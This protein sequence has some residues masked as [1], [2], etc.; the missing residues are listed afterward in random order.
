V[1]KVQDVVTTEFEIVD[2]P[3]RLAI[4]IKDHA[5]VADIPTVMARNLR[6][7]LNYVQRRGIEVSGPPFT[8]YHAWSFRGVEFE[9][10]LPVDHEVQA[11]GRIR[12]FNLP[13]T[14]AVTTIHRGSYEG[15]R[16]TYSKMEKWMKERGLVPSMS[17]WEEYSGD[18]E[19]ILSDH[20][21]ARIV[22]PIK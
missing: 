7:L 14:R 19:D 13:A 4:T 15:L 9:S 18:L 20:L 3:F 2:A 12:M 21:E 22:W 1:E 6:D 16:E 17:M 11:G 5:K 8:Y 10:G